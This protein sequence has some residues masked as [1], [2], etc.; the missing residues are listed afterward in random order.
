V[1]L[2]MLDG[3]DVKALKAEVEVL[4]FLKQGPFS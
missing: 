3:D 1:G 2:S 4:P